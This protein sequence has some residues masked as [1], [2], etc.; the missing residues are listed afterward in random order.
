MMLIFHHKSDGGQFSNILKEVSL[1]IIP[2]DDCQKAL[3]K[4]RL[5]KNFRK[6]SDLLS[7]PFGNYDVCNTIQ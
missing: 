3:R 5:G 7:F 1:P 2:Q 4:T 6:F